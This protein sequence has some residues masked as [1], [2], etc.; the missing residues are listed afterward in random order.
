[1]LHDGS[2][3]VIFRFVGGD[4]ESIHRTAKDVIPR[5]ATILSDDK[6]TV[7][8]GAELLKYFEPDAAVKYNLI[9]ANLPLAIEAY[10]ALAQGV[11][12]DGKFTLS[13]FK[14]LLP[15]VMKMVKAKLPI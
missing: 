5:V 6:V 11:A 10:N 1:M 8:E 12:D 3:Y 14:Y 2:C 7:E 4:E 13:D 15:V 9:L